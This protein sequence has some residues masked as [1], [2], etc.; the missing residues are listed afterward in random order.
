[1][2]YNGVLL[3]EISQCEAPYLMIGELDVAPDFSRALV[4]K[5]QDMVEVKKALLRAVDRP[6]QDGESADG[7][8]CPR[9]GWSGCGGH[10]IVY[11]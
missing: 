9:C 2:N 6:I 7:Y 1:M 5:G 10:R 8:D 3:T 11:F 4:L